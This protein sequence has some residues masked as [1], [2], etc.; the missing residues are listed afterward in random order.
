MELG[1]LKVLL[2][3]ELRRTGNGRSKMGGDL[4]RVACP[5]SG[6]AHV[7]AATLD[8]PFPPPEPKVRNQDLTKSDPQFF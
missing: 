1:T 4:H 2:W 7:T 6:Q 8:Y 5:G 3:E